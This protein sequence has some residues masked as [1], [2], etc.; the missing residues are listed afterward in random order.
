[1]TRAILI[2]GVAIAAL[3]MWL[4]PRWQTRKLSPRIRRFELEDQARKT[5]AQTIGGLLFLVGLAFT[6]KT[7][8]AGAAN[9]QLLR[10]GQQLLRDA[11]I[12]DR[13]TRA[14]EQLGRRD[15][16]EIRLG[17][18]YGL[19]RMIRDSEADREVV[20][21]V[22]IAFVRHNAPW[23]V[24]F[25]SYGGPIV[26]QEPAEKTSPLPD[27]VRAAID[28]LLRHRQEGG[29]SLNKC[30]LHGVR[31]SGILTW[32]NFR[33]SRLS[34]ATF[35]DTDLRRADLGW[36]DVRGA[37]LIDASLEGAMLQGADFTEA[38][39]TGA[40][41]TMARLEGANLTRANLKGAILSG[42]RLAGAVL[43]DTDLR[44]V[45]LTKAKG[46]NQSQIDVACVNGETRL[47]PG[48]TRPPRCC[49]VPPGPYVLGR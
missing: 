34:Y 37:T 12:S 22:L 38:F 32:T 9:I 25:P 11:Q 15:A 39:L 18:I 7:V 29:F 27:D 46:I 14:V 28:V 1:M 19:E 43:S 33:S 21:N 26:P 49:Q 2:L 36:S 45:D 17:G 48:L 40:D 10:E 20:L 13:F 8:E 31:F 24:A 42:A 5:F 6:W 47:P 30:D 3:G 16:I 41:L 4:V 44:G 23:E 35:D